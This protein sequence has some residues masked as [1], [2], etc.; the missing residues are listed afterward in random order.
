M[1][2]EARSCMANGMSRIMMAIQPARSPRAPDELV[3]DV[4][5]FIRMRGTAA[6]FIPVRAQIQKCRVALTRKVRGLAGCSC[7]RAPSL[8]PSN[9]AI[10]SRRH[11]TPPSITPRA[12]R[13]RTLPPGARQTELAVTMRRPTSAFRW[14]TKREQ[15][16]HRQ[17]DERL[18]ELDA[19]VEGE[20]H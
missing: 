3:T 17:H 5:L 9:Y 4:G 14:G 15:R 2:S 7:D 16:G 20:E 13:T 11:K 12:G 19:E 6:P 8:H 1:W 10:A 18:A